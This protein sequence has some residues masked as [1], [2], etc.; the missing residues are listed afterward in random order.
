MARPGPRRAS[1]AKNARIAAE[2]ARFGTRAAGWRTVATPAGKRPGSGRNAHS[3][4]RAN[5]HAQHPQNRP[6]GCPH[7]CDWPAATLRGW[8][9]GSSQKH[10]W[11]PRSSGSPPS[12]SGTGP[13][14]HRAAGW[15]TVATPAGKRPGGSLNAYSPARANTHAQYAQTRLQ[16]YPHG[17]DGPAAT[18]RGLGKAL[19]HAKKAARIFRGER[20]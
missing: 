2:P 5:T 1:P 17:C 4:A 16:G 19:A 7:G 8:G 15:R 9:N 11:T 14:R 10:R 18:L 12:Y 6:L 20:L 3:P 13:F